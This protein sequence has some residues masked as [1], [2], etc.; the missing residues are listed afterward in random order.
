MKSFTVLP[1]PGGPLFGT[2]QVSA[3]TVL[4]VRW[5]AVSLVPSSYPPKF[6]R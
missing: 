4:W 1:C 3:F 2:Y 6:L 5:A